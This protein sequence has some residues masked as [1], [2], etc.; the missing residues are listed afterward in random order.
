MDTLPPKREPGWVVPNSARA[1]WSLVLGA[2]TE[3]L[4][5][6]LSRYGWVDLFLHDS[7]HTQ[8][9]MSYE[10]NAAWPHISNSGV[11]ICD[12]VDSTTAFFDFCLKVQRHPLVLSDK[13]GGP[14]RFG[15]IKKSE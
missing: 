2:S 1:N 7:E 13:R 6:E 4:P 14:I 10:F 8:E 3:M 15:L 5:V 9:T 11:L 12:N